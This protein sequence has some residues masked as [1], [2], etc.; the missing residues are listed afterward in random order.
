LT[1]NFCMPLSKNSQFKTERR[2]DVATE[3]LLLYR[4]K[5]ALPK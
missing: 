3:R 1:K 2:S 5:V 4:S